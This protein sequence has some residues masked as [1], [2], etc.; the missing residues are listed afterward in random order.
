METSLAKLS[1]AN[2][3]SRVSIIIPTYNTARYIAQA[4]RSVLDQT[5]TS[6]EIIVVDD[7]S[8]DDTHSVLQPYNDCIRYARQE[9]QQGVSAARNH[10]MRL[11][12]GEFV[13][14]LD[15]DDFLLPDK[16][17]AQIAYFEA[18]PS[19]GIVHSGWC[20]VNQQGEVIADVEPWYDAPHLNLETWLLWKPVFLG[21]MMFRRVWLELSGGFNAHLCQA[22]DVDLLLRLSL[23]GCK[24]AWVC[25]PTVHYRQH[26]ENTMQN[27]LQQAKDLDV[28]IDDFFA[29]PDVPGAIRRLEKRVRYFTWMW[30][31]WHLYC[32]GNAKSIPQY[33]RQTLDYSGYTPESTVFD[34]VGQFAKRL[35]GV[36]RG[37]DELWAML[38]HFKTAAQCNDNFWMQ[39]ERIM[40]WWVDVWWHYLH[41]KCL[42]Q[43]NSEF[44]ADLNNMN[45]PV[46]LQQQFEDNGISLS[47]NTTVV[48][49]EKDRRW[50]I[51]DA[52]S[53]KQNYTIIRRKNQLNIYSKDHTAVKG[54]EAYRGLAVRELVKLAQSS[55]L[56]SPFPRLAVEFVTEFWRDVR[57]NQ[58]VLESDH[59]EV[60]ALYLTAFGQ[61][62]FGRHWRVAWEALWRAVHAGIRR[63]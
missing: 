55:L 17:A 63:R 37:S 16:L 30:I 34:W 15:A 54:L 12:Q 24:A 50:L 57:E 56:M 59:H 61:A 44:R 60:T 38:P 4:V 7:G 31:V 53:T 5:Y 28:V 27:G 19:L 40:Q 23:M 20:L 11:A 10:G 1:S 58:I 43:I 39:L 42:F 52:D 32:T 8:T 35:R 29:Q 6:Y 51:C 3:V 2:T 41:K 22:E 25:K 33:L 36:G 18:Q 48:A 47:P 21:A 9:N 46:D 49:E 14:F 45:I 26:E 62:A 13:V